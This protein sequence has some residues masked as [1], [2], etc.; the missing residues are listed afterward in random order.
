MAQGHD[1]IKCVRYLYRDLNGQ[2]VLVC[3][4]VHRVAHLVEYKLA[5]LIL[6][7]AIV[8]RNLEVA[9][10]E[11]NDAFSAMIFAQLDL[12]LE[13]CLDLNLG[14]KLHFEVNNLL[15]IDALLSL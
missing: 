11:H 4:L 12:L 7:S 13:L 10:R 5:L 15:G 3:T 14:L 6:R 9:A 8:E 1:G 2:T